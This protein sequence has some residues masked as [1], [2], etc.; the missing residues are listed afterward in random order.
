MIDQLNGFRGTICLRE[1]WIMLEKLD[2]SKFMFD[3]FYHFIKYGGMVKNKVNVG[4]CLTIG[5]GFVGF[6]A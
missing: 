3:C 1:M 6:V 4:R 5:L 2:L